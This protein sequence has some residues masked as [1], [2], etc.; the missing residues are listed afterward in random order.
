MNDSNESA[1]SATYSFRHIFR[2]MWRRLFVQ[3]FQGVRHIF[4]HIRHISPYYVGGAMAPPV[5]EGLGLARF[6][7]KTQFLFLCLI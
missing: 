6:K 4:R 7:M 1:T 3:R 5:R 2:N